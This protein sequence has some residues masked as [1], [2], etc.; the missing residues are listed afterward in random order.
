MDTYEALKQFKAE[1]YAS[2]NEQDFLHMLRLETESELERLKT[3]SPR[4]RP[5]YSDAVETAYDRIVDW[6]THAD[7]Y[8]LA[9]LACFVASHRTSCAWAVFLGK[10]ALVKKQIYP[11]REQ[12][13][14]QS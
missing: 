14:V 2:V 3:A 5:K 1:H 12:V 11:A 4:S 13:E 10:R 8:K 7:E 6:F 9:D